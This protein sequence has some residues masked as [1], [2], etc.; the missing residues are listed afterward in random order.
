MPLLSA[1]ASGAPAQTEP[2]GGVSAQLRERVARAEQRLDLPT[3]VQPAVPADAELSNADVA[4]KLERMK[5]Q[6]AQ[7][8]Q[9]V[10]S[11]LTALRPEARSQQQR[12]QQSPQVHKVPNGVR[13]QL[14]SPLSALSPDRTSALAPAAPATR[15]RSSSPVPNGVHLNRRRLESAI[16]EE[17]EKRRA[18]S[19]RPEPRPPPPLDD[20]S[21]GGGDGG[22][23]GGGSGG[24]SLVG[25]APTIDAVVST[26]TITSLQQRASELARAVAQEA[27]AG[28]QSRRE[29][30]LTSWEREAERA[31]HTAAAG[32]QVAVSRSSELEPEPEPELEPGPSPHGVTQAL[33]AVDFEQIGTRAAQLAN[34]VAMEQRH[35]A[36]VRM[37]PEDSGQEKTSWELEQE[38]KQMQQAAHI[39]FRATM[40]STTAGPAGGGVDWGP[41]QAPGDGEGNTVTGGDGHYAGEPSIVQKTP[42]MLTL[43][44]EQHDELVTQVAGLMKTTA[45]LEAEAAVLEKRQ[46]LMEE[47]E[48]HLREQAAE[49]AVAS[50]AVE[51]AGLRAAQE[52]EQLRSLARA[53]EVDRFSLLSEI[54]HWQTLASQSA[55]TQEQERQR[56][57][58]KA[59]QESEKAQ[60]DYEK[61]NEGITDMIA[62]AASASLRLDEALNL[63]TNSGGD[64]QT[65][66]QP[67]DELTTAELDSQPSMPMSPASRMLVE[68]RMKSQDL[69]AA[70]VKVVD[71]DEVPVEAEEEEATKDE[72]AEEAAA[73][74]EALRMQLEEQ[75]KELAAVAAAVAESK[76]A[77]EASTAAAIAAARA[78]A[79][80]EAAA[81]AAAQ[82]LPEPEL[83]PEPEP[84]PQPEPEPE[85]QKQQQ[86]RGTTS[87]VFSVLDGSAREQQNIAIAAKV[88]RGVASPP[89]PA[90]NSN[91]G[92]RNSYT[93]SGHG[94]ENESLALDEL[95]ELWGV[96]VHVQAMGGGGS[97]WRPT[98]QR[99][100]LTPERGPGMQQQQQQQQQGAVPS[101]AGSSTVWSSPLRLPQSRRNASAHHQSPRARNLQLGGSGGGSGGGGGGG[102]GGGSRGGRQGQTSLSALLARRA[103][104]ASAFC[105]WK[106][107][108]SACAVSRMICPLSP[109]VGTNKLPMACGCHKTF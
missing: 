10:Q 3:A 26:D 102:G 88:L 19:G 17:L 73:E 97:P 65:P 54:S 50:E 2:G 7:I 90:G 67:A 32:Q 21:G 76:A 20:G 39:Y 74:I 41:R 89:S 58:L 109:P 99:L 87:A 34:S 69:A 35:S 66:G 46:A 25:S 101:P 92:G 57:A 98:N 106:F 49:L 105:R 81:E 82:P 29:Q 64:N 80:A 11:N 68:R 59:A 63:T 56:V 94:D 33:E 79:K 72:K 18:L 96:P 52:N 47:K 28:V 60:I 103:S 107:S 91:S 22:G 51:Q 14:A 77:A 27:E 85:E 100:V 36:L 12:P 5:A 42:R 8:S 16:A 104:L 84:Q 13:V 45:E 48:A 23:G 86:P 61:T 55:L 75:A 37:P 108:N 44:I 24:D 83:E 4:V 15:H 31:R 9:T 93:H 53:G 30:P 70:P 1:D 95:T 78:E 43:A 71:E 6:A 38:E 62:E 40:A